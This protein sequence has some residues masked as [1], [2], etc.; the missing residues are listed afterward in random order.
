MKKTLIICSILLLPL[1]L[2]ECNNSEKYD[3]N[4]PESG[5][6]GSNILSVS[7][8]LVPDGAYSLCAILGE[9]ADLKVKISGK[10]WSYSVSS[11]I[12]SWESGEFSFEDDSR[13]FTALQTGKIDA[14][15]NLTK[16]TFIK[17]ESFENGDTVA[18]WTNTFNVY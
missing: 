16:E 6:F 14:K 11:A 8:N 5:E 9:K 13:I 10:Y 2:P 12:G 3:I 7:T 1:L 4:Y 18:T 15:I 17:I